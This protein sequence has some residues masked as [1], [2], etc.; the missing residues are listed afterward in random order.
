V[1]GDGLEDLF[2]SGAKKQ[3]SALYL[4]GEGGQ[5]VSHQPELFLEDEIAEDVAQV[6]FDA[7]NDGDLDLLVV[8]GGNEFTHGAPLNPRFYENKDRKSTRLNSSHVKI[9]YAVFCLKKKKNTD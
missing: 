5:F 1:N 4:Q 7:D 2:I 3:P 8:S 6:F 9:S